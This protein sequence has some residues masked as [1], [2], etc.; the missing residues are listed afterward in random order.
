MKIKMEI[1]NMKMV[2]VQKYPV[3]SIQ[4]LINLEKI[5]LLNNKNKNK[6]IPKINHY[7]KK[8]PAFIKIKIYKKVK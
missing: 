1:S 8:I 2:L 6:V 3:F 4:L 5:K 7:L